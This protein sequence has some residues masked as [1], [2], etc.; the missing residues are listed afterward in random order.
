MGLFRKAIEDEFVIVAISSGLTMDV[1][2]NGVMVTA[3]ERSR[4]SYWEMMNPDG[5]TV[6]FRS[7]ESDS[8]ARAEGLVSQVKDFIVRD[9]SFAEFKV[10]LSE[11]RL[12]TEVNWRGRICFPP[13]GGAANDAF[14]NQKGKT[15]L[16]NNTPEPIGARRASGSA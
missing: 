3:I 13:M 2:N 10:G 15:E 7:R 1:D 14:K 16:Q 11:G 9:D 6:F 4:P 8:R 12:I 5:Y